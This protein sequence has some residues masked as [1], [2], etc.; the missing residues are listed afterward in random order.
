[1]PMAVY[2]FIES[3]KWQGKTVIPFC[4][5]EGSR[6]STT[7]DTLREKCKGATVL[8][9]LEIIGTKFAYSQSIEIGDWL[10]KLGLK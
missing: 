1:M 7:Y 3:Q 6:E 9:G 10:T 2:T 5:H 4:T 8:D